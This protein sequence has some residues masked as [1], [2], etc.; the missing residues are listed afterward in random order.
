MAK[1]TNK[2]VHVILSETLERLRVEAAIAQGKGVKT[3]SLTE[4]TKDLHFYPDLRGMASFQF[5]CSA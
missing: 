4:L 5:P 2:Q 1:D 3:F